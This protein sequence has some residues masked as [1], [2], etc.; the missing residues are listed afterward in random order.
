VSRILKGIFAI[1][2]LW[3]LSA[4]ATPAQPGRMAP[5]SAVF[6]GDGFDAALHNGI[7]VT[8]V[9]GGEK[10]HPLWVSKVGDEEMREA[11]RLSLQQY[12][13]Y[14][15]SEA[16]APF[17]LEVFL[18]ELRQPVNGLAMIV[19]SVVRYKLVRSSDDRAIYDDVVTASYHA[20]M[21]EA[22]I[23]VQRVKL[24][25]EGSIRANIASFLTHLHSLDSAKLLTGSK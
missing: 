1:A 24:A 18:I 11:L 20:A 13:V 9:G 12:G 5:E 23:S 2:M 22:L 6:R 25:N 3:A 10:T 4:C 19:T 16:G 15:S 14:A 17:R 8:K 21:N 7:A